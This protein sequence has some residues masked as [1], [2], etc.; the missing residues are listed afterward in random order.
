MLFRPHDL[1]PAQDA[2]ARL[3]LVEQEGGQPVARV[4]GRARDQDEMACLS[5]A[6]DEPFAAMDG[7][8]VAALFGAG[9]VPS[10]SPSRPGRGFAPSAWPHATPE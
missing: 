4:V 1:D 7:I 10:L 8:G 6:G 3:V 2:P 5:G 9:G